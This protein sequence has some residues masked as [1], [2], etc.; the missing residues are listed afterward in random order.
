[1][2][3]FPRIKATTS[4]DGSNNNYSLGGRKYKTVSSHAVLNVYRET[5]KQ[6]DFRPNF[7]K[8]TVSPTALSVGT[9]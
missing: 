7:S 2:L 3:N 9:L 8:T 4:Y 1:M 5:V 6:K